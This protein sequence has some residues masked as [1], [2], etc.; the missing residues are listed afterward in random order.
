MLATYLPPTP[1]DDARGRDLLHRYN[2]HE[3]VATVADWAHEWVRNAILFGRL[4]S[5]NQL[6][7]RDIYGLRTKSPS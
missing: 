7:T 4:L 5:N 1:P 6:R 2:W 3:D